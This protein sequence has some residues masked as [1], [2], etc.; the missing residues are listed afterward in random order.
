MTLLPDQILD[1]KRNPR[2]ISSCTFN[3]ATDIITIQAERPHNLQIGDLVTIQ[4][5]KDGG[6]GGSALGEDNKE[7]NGEFTVKIYQTV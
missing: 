1:F 5:I 7:Y 6:S 4:N 2:F 3:N